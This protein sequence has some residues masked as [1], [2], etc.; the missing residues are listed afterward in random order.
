MAGLASQRK[1]ASRLLKCGTS[2]VRF[3]PARIHDIADAITAADLRRLINDGVVTAAPVQ[4]V[5][6]GRASKQRRQKSRGRRKGT[7]SRKGRVA[8]TG[9]RAWLKRIRSIRA[10][11]KQLRDDRKLDKR[12]YRSLYRMAKSGFFRSRGHL[13]GHLEKENVLKDVKKE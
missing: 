12:T 4:G 10:A 6:T 8:G 13:A 5:S 3:D 11:L 1:I 9:K 2:R 7:G